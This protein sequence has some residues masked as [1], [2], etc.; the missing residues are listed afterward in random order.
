MRW[1]AVLVALTGC[2]RLLG[3]DDLAG[4]GAIDA[5]TGDSAAPTTV[6]VTGHVRR[7]DGTL[8]PGAVHLLD[9][10][11]RELASTALDVTGGYALEVRGPGPFDVEVRADGFGGDV[12]PLVVYFPAPLAADTTAELVVMTNG[13]LATLCNLAGVPY[14]QDLAQLYV[15]VSDAA[16]RPRSG[17]ALKLGG[18]YDDLL[19]SDDGAV[20]V[21]ASATSTD[22]RAYVFG[23]VPGAHDV[24]TTGFVV[25]PRD[26]ETAAG[27]DTFVE[28][29][30]P[31]P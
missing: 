26:V 24:Q 31:P 11:H 28:V 20:P 29:R 22:G 12:R 7:L 9:V 21:H 17:V 4:P 1:F 27:T 6:R 5:A 13:E 10:A 30:L 16:G 19:Y 14:A 15:L 2:G 23:T 25:A 18:G 3:I 8:L